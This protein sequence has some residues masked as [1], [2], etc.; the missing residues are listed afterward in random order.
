M[1]DDP[2]SVR[3]LVE[4]LFLNN[5]D[6]SMTEA[7]WRQGKETVKHPVR[8]PYEQLPPD[9]NMAIVT[10]Q[11]GDGAASDYQLTRTPIATR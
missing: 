3:D 1:R 10:T 6:G 7:Y 2:Q 11:E 4:Q 9:W 5:S 8:P